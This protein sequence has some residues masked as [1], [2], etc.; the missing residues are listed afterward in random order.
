MSIC[1]D[2]Q[3]TVTHNRTACLFNSHRKRPLELYDF[4]LESLCWELFKF[5]LAR[6]SLQKR[7]K[8][9]P[10]VLQLRQTLLKH[11]GD[12][13]VFRLANLNSWCA[14]KKAN[15]CTCYGC[16]FHVALI[17]AFKVHFQIIT[18]HDAFRC[19]VLSHC[20]SGVLKHL[21]Q[22]VLSNRWQKI[23]RNVARTIRGSL[24]AW[25][26]CI[27]TPSWI[28]RQNMHIFISGQ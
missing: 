12:G 27:W 7:P 18:V 25:T 13:C 15:P 4:P 6:F 3:T 21:P 16:T 9:I 1:T 14:E 11:L 5:T 24:S 22:H 17:K 20:S 10:W 19:F 2:Q 8:D 26:Y 23:G 28:F